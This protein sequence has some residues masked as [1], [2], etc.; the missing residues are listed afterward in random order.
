MI[1][2][3]TQTPWELASDSQEVSKLK[4]ESWTSLWGMARKAYCIIGETKS[5]TNRDEPVK[6]AICASSAT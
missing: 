3:A 4:R 6:S 1:C 5:S 2:D